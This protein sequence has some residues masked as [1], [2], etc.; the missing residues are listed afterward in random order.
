MFRSKIKKYRV[1]GSGQYDIA[2]KQ[3]NTWVGKILLALLISGW[4]FHFSIKIVLKVTENGFYK[5]LKKSVQ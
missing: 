5:F 1:K 2:G 4:N 3:V